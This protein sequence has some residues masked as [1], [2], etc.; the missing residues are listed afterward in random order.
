MT[1]RVAERWASEYMHLR[2]RHARAQLS[3]GPTRPSPSERARSAISPAAQAN[4]REGHS[5]VGL[6]SVRAINHS[7]QKREPSQLN[8]GLYRVGLPV[9]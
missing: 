3:S 4:T 2:A 1:G 9:I 5:P 7:V 6:I 8:P